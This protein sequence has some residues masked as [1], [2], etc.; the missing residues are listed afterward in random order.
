MSQFSE[1]RLR[2]MKLRSFRR[3]RQKVINEHQEHGLFHQDDIVSTSGK[4]KVS[5]SQ[6]GTSL[7][8]YH[9][10]VKDKLKEI[11]QF[12]LRTKFIHTFIENHPSGSDYL[13]FTETRCSFTIVNLKTGESFNSMLN[14]EG[15]PT[16]WRFL[17]FNPSPDGRYLAGDL[18]FPGYHSQVAVYDFQ[19][20]MM[21]EWNMLIP[22]GGNESIIGHFNKWLSNDTFEHYYPEEFHLALGMWENDYLLGNSEDERFNKE[23]TSD[24]YEHIWVERDRIETKTV[25]SKE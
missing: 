6:V 13:I 22:L 4:Y 23:V 15:F 25:P 24:A 8:Y 9:I 14:S 3:D 1:E 19:N 10:T 7:P 2:Q 12:Y 17:S 21:R 11:G 16:N 20:P 18:H 5:V